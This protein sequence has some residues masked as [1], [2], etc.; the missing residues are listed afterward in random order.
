M[1]EKA[2]GYIAK[3]NRVLDLCTGSGAIAIALKKEVKDTTVVASD[4]SFNALEVARENAK[5][6]ECEVEFIRGDLLEPFIAKE[7]FD[8]IVSNPPYI[9]KNYELNNFVKH[10]PS[11]AL[12][13]DNEGLENYER[14]IQQLDKV[15]KKG[16]V[17]LFEIGYNQK[18]ALS[19]LCAK[20]LENY[21]FNCYKD[22]NGKDRI[23]VIKLL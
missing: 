5:N 7:Q 11:I 10:E 21:D 12:Y 15:L 13:A 3:G 19:N 20:Y 16:G 9:S 6:N 23:V 2:L 18:D 22:L 17:I 8:V 1:V 14:I 4:I